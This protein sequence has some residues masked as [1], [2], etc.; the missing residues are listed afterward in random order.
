MLLFNGAGAGGT[1]VTG[2]ELL[3]RTGS[4]DWPNSTVGNTGM[5]D[6]S[7]FEWWCLRGLFGDPEQFRSEGGDQG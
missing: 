3:T 5:A 7:F 6:A 1:A 2:L 4:E